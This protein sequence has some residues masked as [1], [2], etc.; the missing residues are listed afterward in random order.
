MRTSPPSYPATAADPGGG[1]RLAQARVLLALSIVGALLLS[2]L[3]SAA[4]PARRAA[5]DGDRSVPQDLDVMFIGAHPDDEAFALATYGQWEEYA[6]L[7]TGV[8]T[9]TR[10][11]GGGNAVGLEEGPALGLLR[12]REERRAVGLAGI[13]N[14][15]YLDKVDFYYTVSAPLTEQAWGRESTLARIVRVI[16]HTRPETI[17][18][19]N[20]SPTPGNHGHHQQA[21]RLAIEAFAAA[22]DPTRF[23]R[24]LS[25][26]GLD[27]FRVAKLFR[28]GAT[29]T[30]PNGPDCPST[31]VPD[32]PTED[33]ASVF[34]GR[35]SE[36][37]GTSWAAVERDAQRM[38]ASQGWAVFP[39]VPTDPNL[40]GCDR[41]TLIDSRVPYTRGNTGPLATLEGASVPAAGGYRLGTEFFLTTDTFATS[42]GEALEVTAHARGAQVGGSRVRLDVPDGWTV[43]GRRRLRGPDAAGEWT[44]TFTVTPPADAAPDRYRLGATLGKNDLRA[45]TGEVVEVT[46][47][48]VATVEP[49]PQVAHY[50]QWVRELG[51]E[52]IDNLI[53]PRL[54][55]GSGRSRDIRVDV[56]N[57]S[58]EARDAEVTLTLPAGFAVDPASQ[59]VDD[60]AAGASTSVTFSVTNTDESL[61]TAN[62]GGEG[63]DYAM[64]V[65]TTS[66]GETATQQAALNLVPTT[67]IEAVAATPTVDG[68]IGSDEYAG[69]ILDLSRRWEGQDPDS[70]ADASGT[71]RVVRF[72]DDLYVAVTVVDDVLGAVLTPADAKRHWRT[73][74]VELAFD[75]RGTS[76]NTSTTFKVGIFP[77]T[78]DPDDGNPPAAYRDAD[79]FQG[80]IAQTAPAMEVAS[81]V[82]EPYTGYVIEAKIP[83]AAL[84]AAVDPERLGMN[85]FI[86]DSDTDD[87]TGQTRL[88]WSTFGGV[89]GDPYRWGLATLPGYT[90]P[91]REPFEPVLPTEAAQ[92][93][94]SP[95][96]ILQSTL[97]GVPLAGAAPLGRRGR[98]R[99]DGTPRI[100]AAGL[101]VRLA[102]RRDGTAHVFAWNG[103][104]SVA[105]TEVDVTAGLIERV[106]VPLTA[107]QATSLRRNGTVLVGF[108]ASGGRLQALSAR[109]RP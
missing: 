30:G 59:P 94:E 5:G 8:I 92:S 98:L 23:P 93:V 31:F 74:S 91:D 13:E 75:P 45:R 65:T 16:R 25:R 86:Y 55:L 21:A 67:T 76:E 102:A 33:I 73:D 82:T 18:T 52:Q 106:V 29:G 39:D 15:Y 96:S 1:R 53:T 43:S 3:P 100:T 7:R 2:A 14:V 83:L 69:E 71:A 78:D 60:L 85:L 26:E 56:T 4:A 17:I 51:V 61:P 64:T 19:M 104:R 88:G 49:L 46:P 79:A 108:E 54:S 66:A 38:Y 44:T 48:V 27:T 22:A 58:T 41:F 57:T 36:R 10:G 6:G 90:P 35:F 109:V 9:I 47:D 70:P 105:S 80:P 101:V 62:Q 11:E 103:R 63:G 107:D 68:V 34:S 72:G 24:Q 12:E 40:L 77:V 42:A 32:E 97:D 37:W 28:G 99:I 95:Q 81:S 20:P 84:P 87:K 89:Q 50:R